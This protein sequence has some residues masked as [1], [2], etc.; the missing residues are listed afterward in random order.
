MQLPT[1]S[2]LLTGNGE[3][4]LCSFCLHI[5]VYLLGH[6]FYIKTHL[7]VFSWLYDCTYTEASVTL[8]KGLDLRNGSNI[9]YSD[10]KQQCIFLIKYD[11]QIKLFVELLE[12]VIQKFE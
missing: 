7:G 1:I 10:Y 4:N 12:K 11:L 3:I 2:L 6:V 5:L 9:F 8:F